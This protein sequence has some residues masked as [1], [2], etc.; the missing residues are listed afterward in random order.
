MYFSPYRSLRS[1]SPYR[2]SPYRSLRSRSP[3]RSLRSRS[4]YRRSLSRSPYRRSL[5]SRSPYRRSPSRSPYRRSPS[6][7]PYRR[8][9][10][11]GGGR[12]KGK[13]A[14]PK[15]KPKAK[16]KPSLSA[17]EMIH[18]ELLRK[19]RIES[20]ESVKTAKIEKARADSESGSVE[21][22]EESEEEEEEEDE[23]EE[24][25]EEESTNHDIIKIFVNNIGNKATHK[26]KEKEYWGR[27]EEEMYKQWSSHKD[28]QQFTEA[29][30]LRKKLVGYRP[31][32]RR[33]EENPHYG[34]LLPNLFDAKTNV[35]KMINQIII[36]HIN[37]SGPTII[38]IQEIPL[39]GFKYQQAQLKTY[40][41]ET[42]YIFQGG[43]QQ[44]FLKIGSPIND[45]IDKDDNK[46]FHGNG[47]L[48]SKGIEF[49]S[50][51]IRSNRLQIITFKYNDKSFEIQNVHTNRDILSGLITQTNKQTTDIP[52]II[53]G[54]IQL[55]STYRYLQHNLIPNGQIIYLQ[56][57]KKNAN[58]ELS[59]SDRPDTNDILILKNKS[60]VSGV[61]ITY[62][63]MMPY[64]MR[65][66]PIVDPT[67]K[68]KET[69]DES[70]EKDHKIY[71]FVFNLTNDTIE[72]IKAPMP[73]NLL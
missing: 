15:A 49:I 23:V 56:V 5:H 39:I 36:R 21:E 24:E 42:P 69:S 9:L 64:L 14:K 72:N 27:K 73:I 30:I 45:F 53:S 59:D 51:N 70:K 4:P 3:Y 68:Q 7:S 38:L 16:A 25:E 28:R 46:I 1:R 47:I 31:E 67:F 32:Q 20:L 71:G 18:L 48:Y 12:K 35:I 11:C 60:S 13:K 66:M 54:D 65:D 34:V 17:E 6:R 37:T 55:K 63:N 2:R 19:N 33:K 43:G 61:P 26:K 50:E 44:F 41:E 62:V 22:K 40:L 8:S 52:I 29:D 58:S 57:N 10:I